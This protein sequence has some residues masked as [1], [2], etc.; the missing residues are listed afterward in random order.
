MSWLAICKTS[1]GANC[2]WVRGRRLLLGQ[3]PGFSKQFGPAR[4]DLIPVVSTIR[5]EMDVQSN[6][7]RLFAAKQNRLML[8][9][10]RHVHDFA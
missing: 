4:I 10:A 9:T 3:A 8:R 6:R 1:S 2:G 5:N 7:I